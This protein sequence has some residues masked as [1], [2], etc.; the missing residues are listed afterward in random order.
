[1][2]TFYLE[3]DTDWLIYADYLDDQNINN[4]IREDLQNE[5][6]PWNLELKKRGVGLTCVIIGGV[7]SVGLTRVGSADK[8]GCSKKF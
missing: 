2:N 1:M 3:T 6:I 4:F 5:E 7:G 8:V